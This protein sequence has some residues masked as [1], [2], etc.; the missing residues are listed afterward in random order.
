MRRLLS[1]IMLT[2]SALA[3]G[4]EPTTG[5]QDLC[6]TLA[7]PLVG[8]A[9]GPTVTDVAL[10]AQTGEGI[11]ALATA[12]DPQGGE[13]MRNVLQ[14]LE[15]FPDPRCEGA[16][17]VLQDDLADSGVEE[18]FGIAVSA[19]GNPALFAAIAAAETWPVAVDFAD[20]DGN[21][22]SGRV[23]ARVVR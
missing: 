16:A 10:E 21:R 22:I 1:L 4:D 2:I 6:H 20:L 8:S 12:T 23:L 17:I 7:L 15:V 19:T 13:N 14:S 5:E 11:V 9:A 3:C 18:S